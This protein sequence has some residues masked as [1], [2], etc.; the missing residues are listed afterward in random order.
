[1][2]NYLFILSALAGLLL[3]G[4][5]IAPSQQP[6]WRHNQL[7]GQAAQQQHDIDRAQCLAAARSA[8]APPLAQMPPSTVTNFFANT[9]S[10]YVSGQATTT[11]QGG[12]YGAPVGIQ[13]AN[14]QINYESAF[15]NMALGCMAQRGWSW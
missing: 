6:N 14:A 2:H 12:M 1:M 4:C 9:P 13:Q 11:T 7:T 15:A 3:M 5:A 10:G 8:V